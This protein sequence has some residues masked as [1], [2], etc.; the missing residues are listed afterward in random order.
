MASDTTANILQEMTYVGGMNFA[1]TRLLEVTDP[2]VYG[3]GRKARPPTL[4]AQTATTGTQGMS[5]SASL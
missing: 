4:L 5:R 3:K 1:R 2:K